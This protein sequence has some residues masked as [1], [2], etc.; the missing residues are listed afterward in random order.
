MVVKKTKA[1]KY[2]RVMVSGERHV[3][4]A[5]EAKKQGVSIAQLAE[6]AFAKAFK[7]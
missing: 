6:K 1:P 2:P 4:L 7:K 5:T 3:Q